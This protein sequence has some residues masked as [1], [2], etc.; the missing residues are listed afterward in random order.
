MKKIILIIVCVFAMFASN[1]QKSFGETIGFGT[2]VCN[3]T[4]ICTASNGLLCTESPYSGC[5]GFVAGGCAVPGSAPCP[6]CVVGP[7]LLSGDTYL[8]SLW[9]VLANGSQFVVGIDTGYNVGLYDKTTS[10]KYILITNSTLNN[11]FGTVYPS[12]TTLGLI[13]N[14]NESLGSL[15][16]I[17]RKETWSASGDSLIS[18]LSY[19]THTYSL[20]SY[21]VEGNI[22][23]EDPNGSINLVSNYGTELIKFDYANNANYYLEIY[24]SLGQKVLETPIQNSASYSVG[25]LSSGIYFAI[26]NDSQNAILRREFVIK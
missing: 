14:L 18:V 4:V 19:T 21:R 12:D 17:E 15:T 5:S 1:T 7:C 13:V 6:Y 16:V 2:N 11:D 3:G 10:T 23:K 25:N 24:N 22:F 8:Y 26:I 9:C 20:R